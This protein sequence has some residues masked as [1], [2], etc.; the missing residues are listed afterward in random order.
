M[1]IFRKYGKI[2]TW[3][4]TVPYQGTEENDLEKEKICEKEKQ[5]TKL[6]E[7]LGMMKFFMNSFLS[8]QITTAV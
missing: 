5:K 4:G 3:E 8:C 7:E 2:R 1:L 6:E